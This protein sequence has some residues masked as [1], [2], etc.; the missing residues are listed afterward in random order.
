MHIN[1][2]L[3]RSD[4]QDVKKRFEAKF[5]RLGVD[6][7]WEWTA[8]K[9]PKGYG[10][11]GVVRGVSSMTVAHRVAY[12]MYVGPLPKLPGWHGACVL[13]RCDNPGCVNPAHLFIGT[14]KDNLNDM[15]AKH[16]RVVVH[17]QPGVAMKHAKLNVEQVR[18][19]RD[20]LRNNC[21]IGREYGL[22][23]THVSY[24]KKRRV[25]KNV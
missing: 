10:R 7:C 8:S 21:Q 2:I 14:Q 25:W 3:S 17:P 23:D 9:L 22:S 19:I 24:I 15:D 4:L 5:V 1:D 16:R 13:H 6:E 11:F 18:A 20:D 12:V